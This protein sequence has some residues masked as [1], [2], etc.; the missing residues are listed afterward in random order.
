MIASGMIASGRCGSAFG[1]T[2]GCGATAEQRQKAKIGL[3][4]R[5]QLVRRLRDLG[6]CRFRFNTILAHS[7]SNS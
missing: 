5:Q 4:V 7:R 1:G 2:D 6:G 3:K